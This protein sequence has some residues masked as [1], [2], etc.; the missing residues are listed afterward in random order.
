MGK[1]TDQAHFWGLCS[2]NTPDLT[3]KSVPW[4]HIPA[5]GVLE[6]ETRTMCSKLGRRKLYFIP[7]SSELRDSKARALNPRAAKEPVVQRNLGSDQCQKETPWINMPSWSL[8][9]SS[10]LGI[11]LRNSWGIIWHFLCV[12]WTS[13]LLLYKPTPAYPRFS[14]SSHRPQEAWGKAIDH[15][16]HKNGPSEPTEEKSKVLTVRE[17]RRERVRAGT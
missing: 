16:V 5:W 15:V 6:Q 3:L 2:S 17:G 1:N 8:L 13:E 12:H 10:S 14:L 9:V 7:L 11:S 4:L